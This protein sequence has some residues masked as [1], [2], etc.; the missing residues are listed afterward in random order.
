M[1]GDSL[2]IDDIMNLAYGS[3]Y[4]YNEMNDDSKNCKMVF[5]DD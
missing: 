1:H 2:M 3:S 4:I 5:E